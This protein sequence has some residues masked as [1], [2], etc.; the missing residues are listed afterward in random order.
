MNTITAILL[1]WRRE[2]NLPRIIKALRE[3]DVDKIWLWDN[4]GSASY[5]RDK[6]DTYAHGNNSLGCSARWWLAQEADTD[7]VLVQDD[8]LV[9]V[10]GGLRLLVGAS[11]GEIVVGPFGKRL[12]TGKTYGKCPLAKRGRVDMLLG[13]CMLLPRDQVGLCWPCPEKFEDDIYVSSQFTKPKAVVR[14]VTRD[15]DP[16]LKDIAVCARPGH[17]EAREA[18]RRRWF[19]R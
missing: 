12:L 6:V 1:N 13:R 9:L 11:H 4:S 10:P 7:Y 15:L 3:Q 18:A 14:G 5:L 16:G 17:Y 2:G 19:D 8:D